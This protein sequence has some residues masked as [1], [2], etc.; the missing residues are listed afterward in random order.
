MSS[1]PNELEDLVV[2][3]L[4][5]PS[6]VDEKF[7]DEGI[8]ISTMH[9]YNW[10][11]PMILSHR[12]ALLQAFTGVLLFSWSTQRKLQGIKSSP[13]LNLLEHRINSQYSAVYLWW[14]TKN[15]TSKFSSSIGGLFFGVDNVLLE[16]ETWFQQLS[17]AC[18]HFRHQISLVA[19]IDIWNFGVEHGVISIL[20]TCNDYLA[21]N[22]AWAV[23]S[24]S[25]VDIPF[26]LLCSAVEH[27]DLT[28]ERVSGKVREEC[29]KSCGKVRI[30]LLPLELATGIRRRFPDFADEII[31]KVTT[32]ILF[33]GILPNNL[34]STQEENILHNLIKL[35]N[36]RRDYSDIM[37]K[38]KFLSFKSITEVDVSN[39]P[40]L[41]F[42]SV[43]M[44][45]NVAFPS[46]K[47]LKACHYF[48]IT[49]EN[50]HFLLHKC[51]LIDE[52]DLSVDVSPVSSAK[53][54]VLSLHAETYQLAD[55][56]RYRNLNQKL[57][58]LNI[59][60]VIST[61]PLLAN[62]SKLTLEGRADIDD[63]M[64]IKISS[65]VPSLTHLNIK[66]CAL[67]TDL[68]IS[69]LLNKCMNVRSF[70]SSYTAFGRNS[71][72]VLCSNNTLSDGFDGTH[73]NSSSMASKLQQLQI[74]GCKDVD[75]NSLLQLLSQ[76]CMMKVLHL[77]ETLL[78][79]DALFRLASHSLEALDVS[80]TLVSMQALNHA[81]KKNPEMRFLRATG[82][83]KLRELDYDGLTY[84]LGMGLED[85]ID[86]L[87]KRCI[88]EEL[89]LGWGLSLQPLEKL[90]PALSRLKAISVGLGA[91]VDHCLLCLIPEICPLLESVVLRFQVISDDV[92]RSTL[93]SLE[94]LQSLWLSCCLGNLTSLSFRI[95][96]RNLRTLKLE[97]VTPWMTN[98]DLA[99]LAQNCANLQELLLSGCKLLDS[100]SQEIISTGWPGLKYIHLEECGKLTSNGVPFLLKCMAI[101]DLLLRH[102]GKGLARN[103]ILDAAS[104]LP[105]LRK[106]SLDLCDAIE[107]GFDSPSLSA[108]FYLSTL[109]ICRCKHRSCAF[110]HEALGEFKPV[111]KNTIILEWTSNELR[112]TVVKERL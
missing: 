25:F 13:H 21:Q 42:A 34:D 92:I 7:S 26:A 65:M 33:L 8:I 97:W 106:L 55:E 46:L 31:R 110:Q 85:L 82:C 72:L 70:I 95:P 49:Y 11:I 32:A 109:M 29:R 98:D 90:A 24:C 52:V 17:R 86:K 62:I 39:C 38:V 14:S 10:D 16:C 35:D 87:G 79:D 74:D 78:D 28:L 15:H 12:I 71:V 54:T 99:I 66:G 48:S 36:F 43:L 5:D 100:G 83:H 94:H 101:E 53:V 40:Q 96:K 56:M 59:G 47:I 27:S 2:L 9:V 44:W 1:S 4:M 41:R 69:K 91:E 102:N 89:A 75:K 3:E 107:G 84:S 51:P 20:G 103:F 88:L 37:E 111:H 61:K 23:S 77:K 76:I 64:L 68:G 22:F 45:L 50:L 30:C 104:K 6:G 18:G 80:D 73:V 67:L 19:V 57:N 112:T 105:L 60:E 63:L 108:K 58:L 93:A 81:I